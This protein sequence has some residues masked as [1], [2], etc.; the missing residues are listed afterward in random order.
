[1]KVCDVINSCTNNPKLRAILAGTN[2]LYAGIADKTPFYVHALSINS[3]IESAWRCVNGGSQI[4]KLL[5]REI[6]KNGGKTPKHKE[7][8]QFHIEDDRLCSVSTTDG[9]T[10][11]A[12]TFVSN[13]D[14][15][16]TLRLMGD[17]PMRKSYVNHIRQVENTISSFSL[18]IVLKPG[19]VPYLNH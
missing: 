11:W 13:I 4:A 2:L 14:P 16:Q 12:D 8:S 3:Y 9:Y 7:V 19:R 1:L 5:I 10:Y 18:Y 15:K 6:H 17:Y